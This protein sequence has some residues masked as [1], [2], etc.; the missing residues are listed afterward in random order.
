L[1][2]SVTAEHLLTWSRWI[3]QLDMALSSLVEDLHLGG[4]DKDMS[5]VVWGE[6]GLTPKINVE[7]RAMA[8]SASLV[9]YRD[10]DGQPR[11]QGPMEENVEC[12]AR[13]L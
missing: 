4:L 7:S 12:E 8:S 2:L 1:V 5:V 11:T 9:S 3:P 13:S 6:F 10:M